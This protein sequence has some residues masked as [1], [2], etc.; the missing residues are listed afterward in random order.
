MLFF[1]VLILYVIG[2]MSSVVAQLIYTEDT[3]PMHAAICAFAAILWPVFVS[4]SVVAYIGRK[5]AE[6][7]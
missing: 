4:L 6:K 1:T 3:E 7:I 2:M 5:I